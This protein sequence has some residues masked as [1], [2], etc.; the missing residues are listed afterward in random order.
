MHRL[1]PR[2]LEPRAARG[3]RHWEPDREQLARAR[4]AIADERTGAQL[5]RIVDA[6]PH[7]LGLHEPELKTAPRGFDRDH[8]RIDLLRRKRFAALVRLPPEPWLHTPEA[9]DRVA[10]AWRGVTP[11]LA[12]LERHVG[13]RTPG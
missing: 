7:G 12:W 9:K 6:L 10:T 8:P 1:L 5:E 2:A 13:P 3:R 11:L 4:R